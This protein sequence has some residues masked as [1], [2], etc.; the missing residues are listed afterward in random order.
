MQRREALAGVGIAIAGLAG[1]VSDTTDGGSDDTPE[2]RTPEPTHTDTAP[3]RLPIGDSAEFDDGT[4][5]T[6]GNPSVQASIIANLS[7]FLAIQREDG[8]QF[9]VIDV[10][11]D[12]GSDPSSFALERNGTVESPPQ[13]QQRVRSVVRECDGTC[14][15]VPVNAEPVDSA[16]IVYRPDRGPRARWELGTETTTA[17]SEVPELHLDNAVITDHDGNVGLRLTVQNVGDRDGL[18]LALVAPADMADV[19]DPIGFSVPEGETVTE[20]VAPSEIQLPKPD[21]AEFSEEP[22]EDTRRFE[23]NSKS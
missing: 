5:I 6:V 7:A 12:A 23:I 9:V 18:F 3:Q 11:G 20:I 19:E 15:A 10:N 2:G 13:S 1:C 21:E 8:L 22:T 4:S 14:I 16:G 17:L